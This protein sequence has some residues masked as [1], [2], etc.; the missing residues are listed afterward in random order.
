[1]LVTEQDRLRDDI[2]AWGDAGGGSR[3]AL[4]PLLQRVQQKYG[5]I[6][7]FA[8]QVIAD[9]LS[10]HPV[11]VQSVISFYHFL[12]LSARGKFIIR[13]CRTISCDIAGK[14]RL[15][16]Q[17]EN[18]LGIS[19]GE[20]T[21]DGMFTLEWANCIGM[22]DQGPAMLINEKV[23]TRVTPELVHNVLQAC[24]ASFGNI[25]LEGKEEL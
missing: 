10:I 25:G 22:C 15:A 14:D 9:V 1:M 4:I 2:L 20:T 13:L 12:D 8:M 19:F 16:R 18:D 23:F 21:N 11:E 17:L 7:D 5:E 24:R 3:E 6:S